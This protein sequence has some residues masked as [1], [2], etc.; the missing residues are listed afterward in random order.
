MSSPH[1]HP[2]RYAPPPRPRV[3][4]PHATTAPRS[5]PHLALT[6]LV[7][8]RRRRRR[9]LALASGS[10][11]PVLSAPPYA[12]TTVT[13]RR[14]ES[15]HATTT[16]RAPRPHPSRH[17]PPTT[18]RPHSFTFVRHPPSFFFQPPLMFAYEDDAAHDSPSE[19]PS[20]L[21]SGSCAN[22]NA[23]AQSFAFVFAC[24]RS[25]L[26]PDPGVKPRVSYL[27]P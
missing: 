17:A 18:P 19:H 11:S 8:Q 9:H 16:T 20:A 3:D 1:P 13:R 5:R 27:Y 2:S 23:N 4:P 21:G 26:P 6:H 10:S 25:A 22:T 15:P 7:T 12:T 24:E 14:L